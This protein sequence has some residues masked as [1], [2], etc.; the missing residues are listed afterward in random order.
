MGP[1]SSGAGSASFEAARERFVEGLQALQDGDLQEAEACFL[2]SL[3][4]LPGRPS[5]L[6]NLGA[7]RLRLGRP[8]DALAPL[9][10]ALQ[11]EPHNA[12][13]RAQL[14]LALGDLGR[15]AEA[16]TCFDESLQRAPGAPAV[17]FHRALVLLRLGRPA[18]AL[19]VLSEL[20][21]S[22]PD[23][24]ET[25]FRHGQALH[26]LGRVEEALA[27]LDRALAI[28][29]TL[30]AA[31]MH[32]AGLLKDLGR[33]D[34]AAADYEAALAHG[35]DEA[36]ARYLLGALRGVEAPA[37]APP[38]YVAPLFDGYAEQF[39]AH[40]VGELRYRAHE[41]LV[42]QLI[43]PTSRRFASALDLGCGTGLCGPLVRPMVQRLEGVDLSAKMLDKARDRAV[44]DVLT[45]AD[46][47]RHLQTTP[48]R[49]DLVLSTDVF[50]YIGDL[51]PVF[52][53]VRR[54][55]EA[56][57]LFCFSVERADDAVAWELRPSARYAQSERGLR[58]L[59][60]RHGFDVVQVLRA[61]IRQDAEHD[62][63]GLYLALRLA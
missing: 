50:I 43:A 16:L 37:V 28:D 4:A 10:Q 35:A 38:Q 11:A 20:L 58:A 44:Y 49:H 40:L 29:A 5:T 31:L 24:A 52:A 63:D 60:A 32:R 6:S 51:E 27:S 41:V 30:G 8:Q 61:A 26:A 14:G 56:G 53:G 19:P 23:V 18:E 36:L 34:A 3:A 39:E 15:D 45:Q 33:V 2:A 7:V 1:R 12:E 13:T 48:E 17:R 9:Q 57:G 22:S 54:V 47:A 46:V 21:A 25:W 62:V 59:A 42:Q 55:L